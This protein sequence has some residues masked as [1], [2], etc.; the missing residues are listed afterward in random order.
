MFQRGNVDVALTTHANNLGVL[1]LGL[2]TLVLFSH[3]FPLVG[4]ADE[5]FALLTG[6]D[7]GG[8]IAVSGFFIVSGFLVTRSLQV[9]GWRDYAIAR[10]LRLS[11]GLAAMSVICAFVMGPVVTQLSLGDYFSRGGTYKFMENALLFPIHMT[12]PGD[13]LGHPVTAMNG[14]VWTIPIEAAMYCLLVALAAAG[15]ATRR[16]GWTLPLLAVAALLAGDRFWDPDRQFLWS[17]N[18]RWLAHYGFYFAAGVCLYLYRAVVPRSVPLALLALALA[19]AFPDFL[20]SEVLWRVGLVYAIYSIAFGGSLFG[21]WTARN[22]LSYGVYL[23]S[24]PVQQCM[25]E[26]VGLEEITV[27][28][29]FWLSLPVTLLLAYGSWHA[30]ERR[31]L[32]FKRRGSASAPPLPRPAQSQNPATQAL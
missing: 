8:G 30:I 20:L 14:S 18:G 29:L 31:A 16:L 19:M 3:S 28:S 2:A 7:S 24:M 26:W 27:A 17:L 13:F 22:D 1:R 23:Y 25:I 4:R 9:R 32:H 11:P 15:L 21:R 12:L 5:F 6:H 10:F